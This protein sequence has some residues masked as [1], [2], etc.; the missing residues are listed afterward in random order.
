MRLKFRP[1]FGFREKAASIV[2]GVSAFRQTF[3]LSSSG[4]TFVGRVLGNPCERLAVGVEW[5]MTGVTEQVSNR[6]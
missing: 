1:F 3:Q 6:E 2:Y 5:E 4:R